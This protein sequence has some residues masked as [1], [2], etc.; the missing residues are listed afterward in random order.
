MFS[1]SRLSFDIRV[2]YALVKYTDQ[3][4]FTMI[5]DKKQ[6][7]LTEKPLSFSEKQKEGS[8]LLSEEERSL[9]SFA[10]LFQNEF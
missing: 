2:F 8:A 7:G 3:T 5:T 9:A 10:I 1:A 4:Y 6:E